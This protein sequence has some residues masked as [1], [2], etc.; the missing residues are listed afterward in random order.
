MKVMYVT[1]CLDMAAGM[2]IV[3]LLDFNYNGILLWAFANIIGHMKRGIGQY[4]FIFLGIVSYALTD[5]GLLSARKPLFSVRDYIP[6]SYTH[7]PRKFAYT[8]MD[9]TNPF[10]VTIEKAIREAVEANGDE[11]ISTDPVSYTHLLLI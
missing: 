2:F 5:Y 7:L 8:C 1:I 10:F 6:V 9:G 11:L 4:A 3:V